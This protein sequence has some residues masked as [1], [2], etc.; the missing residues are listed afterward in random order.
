MDYLSVANS[1][2][3]WFSAALGVGIVIFQ[4]FL[5]VRK[6]FRTGKELGITPEQFKQAAKASMISSVGPSLVILAG[7]ISLLVTMGGP[8]AWMRLSYIGSVQ[9][10]LMSAEFGAQAMGVS[11]DSIDMNAV[12]F[13]NGV[14]VMALG[15]FGWVLFTALFTHKMDKFR[16]ILAGG[17]KAFMPILSVA[18]VLGAFAYLASDRIMRMDQGTVS[19]IAGFIIM[20]LIVILN[21][22]LQKQWLKEWAMTFAMF[23]GMLIAILL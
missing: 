21:R 14:W 7:M 18:A 13:T 5:F 19:C 10:E 23:G 6:S 20:A 15:S 22:V 3:I 16:N 8:I 12:A 1:P 9:F 17:R 11:L 4:S 2:L